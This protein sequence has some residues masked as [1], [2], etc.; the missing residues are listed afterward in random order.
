MVSL[1]RPMAAGL[2]SAFAA[3]GRK[4]GGAALPR[5]ER[6]IPI[7]WMA[8]AA[9]TLSLPLAALYGWFAAPGLAGHGT[10]FLAAMVAGTAI[11]TLVFGF[12][13]ATA[14][15]YM[16]GLLGSSSSPISGIAV[17][18]TVLVALPLSVLLAG[19]GAPP[20]AARAGIGFALF[21]TAVVVT[22]SSIA[23][24]NLQDL[25]TGALV[26]ATPWRQQAVL[27]LGVAVGS[28]AIAP[29]LQL[30]YTTYGFAGAL[31]HLGMNAAQVLPA[32]QASLVAGI[33]QGIFD[34]KLPWT[35]VLTGVAAGALLIAVDHG[36]Q[37]RGLQLPVLTVGIGVYLPP[38]V[39]LTIAQGGVLGWLAQQAQKRLA[40]DAGDRL[41][42]Q[43][44]RRGVLLVSGFL[45]GESLMG[46]VLTVLQSATGR[47]DA[48]ALAGPNFAG[49]ATWLA[50]A[51]FA[52]AAVAFFRFLVRAPK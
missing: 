25:K 28:L 8:A 2:R 42:E 36:L 16:A 14:C 30:L 35:M 50:A 39:G 34:H 51:V 20:Q 27:L 6:D 3:A 15:G 43:T 41:A 33:T 46:I 44:R 22:I 5:Q 12:L 21:V 49:T 4:Q 26:D 23:N 24:D 18:S 38:T 52:A 47:G 11:F 19:Q 9:A 13:M 31:P 48:V 1:S 40:P 37:R 17:L 45:V 29:V 10:A 7:T 32:P